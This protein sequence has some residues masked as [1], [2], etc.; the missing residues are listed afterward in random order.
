MMLGSVYWFDSF[1]MGDGT[2]IVK[3]TMVGI[4]Q[5]VLR[6]IVIQIVLHLHQSWKSGD[7]GGVR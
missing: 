3:G 4:T 6:R 2:A 7:V 5:Q 1:H